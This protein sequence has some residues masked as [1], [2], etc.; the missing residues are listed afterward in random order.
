MSALRLRPAGAQVGASQPPSC[1]RLSASDDHRKNKNGTARAPF[2]QK[3][4]AILLDLGFTEFDVLARNRVVLLLH[5]LVGHGARIL[6]GDVIEAGVSRRNELDLDGD[7]FGHDG[8][9]KK[10]KSGAGQP[11]RIWPASAAAENGIAERPPIF[12]AGSCC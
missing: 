7:R 10:G 9:L 2:S 6:L 12:R 11:A 3:H 8:S 4:S 5:E 1:L